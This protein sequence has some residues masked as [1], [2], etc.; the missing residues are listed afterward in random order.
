MSAA[1]TGT[2]A[3]DAFPSPF[4]ATGGR[5]ADASASRSSARPATSARSS[6]GCST[7]T[8]T[9]RSS[10]SSRA[11]ATASRSAASSRTSHGT[12]LRGRCRTCPTPTP[13]SSR[14]P[15]SAAAARRAGPGGTGDRAVVD[16]GADFRL[17]D[18]ADYP[19]WYGLEHPAPDL[20]AERRLRP[21]GAPPRRAAAGSAD[22]PVAVVGSPGCYPTA[23]LL[24]LAPLARAGLIATSSWTPRAASP[25]R[26][27]SPRPEMMF[28]E[29]NESVTAPTACRG[30]ATSRR[31]SRSSRGSAR[32]GPSATRRPNPGARGGRLR[33]APHPDDAGDPVGLPRPHDAPRCSQAG[34]RRAVRGGVRR[35]AVRPRGRRAPG[36]EARPREQLRATCIVRLDERTGRI[37]AIGVID[38]LVKGAAGQAVQA[39]NIVLG[40]PET[41]GLGSSRSPRRSRA[42]EHRRAR[43]GGD[44]TD[45][46]AAPDGDGIQ[47]THPLGHPATRAVAG[48]DGP[49]GR[50]RRAERPDGARVRAARP[51]PCAF[52]RRAT[53]RRARTGSSS[54]ASRPAS[55]GRE[56]RTSRS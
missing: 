51:W 11:T 13:S 18:A 56:G 47:T 27:A 37:L 19:H 49:R 36:D 7:V 34:P 52:P 41:A 42:H 15:H 3:P 44:L 25:A 5:T 55:R 12:G 31:W 10:A 1:T 53:R 46:Y 23:T 39:F 40:L 43:R 20:L 33:A 24:A 14:S 6:S 54:E 26:A 22:A 30:T 29:V 2:D 48:P 45:E 17:R 28:A 9:W 32:S 35:R 21:A 4:R 8:R 16:L 38:N 50:G